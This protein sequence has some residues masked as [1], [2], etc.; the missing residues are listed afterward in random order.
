MLEIIVSSICLTCGK[1]KLCNKETIN[2]EDFSSRKGA[3][4]E[5]TKAV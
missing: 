3:R 1:R 4:I 5:A 2:M